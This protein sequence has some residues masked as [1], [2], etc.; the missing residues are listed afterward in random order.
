MYH[1]FFIH[2]SL[3]GRLGCFHVLAIVNSAAAN[4]G[5]HVSFSFMASSR[6]KPSSEIVGSYGSFIPSFLFFVFS[7]KGISSGRINLHSHQQC[8]KVPFPPHSL[9]QLVNPLFSSLL[10]SAHQLPFQPQPCPHLFCELPCLCPVGL[11]SSAL[12][13]AGPGAVCSSV[14]PSA[15]WVL[16]LQNGHQGLHGT[17]G[18]SPCLWGQGAFPPCFLWLL[19]GVPCGW[20]VPSRG[21]REPG[22]WVC[23][24]GVCESKE[25]AAAEATSPGFLMWPLDRPIV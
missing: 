15:Q 12:F 8:R 4:S 2:S 19:C 16:E 9:Q 11:V 5:V 24:W 3:D 25:P 21:S 1:N 13:L 7:P 22:V 18:I 23:P 6:H 20:F 14:C 17:Q 10:V